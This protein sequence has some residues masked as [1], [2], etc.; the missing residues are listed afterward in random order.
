MHGLIQ[1]KF[2]NKIRFSMVIYQIS[3]CIT[4]EEFNYTTCENL[5]KGFSVQINAKWFKNDIY[6]RG[7]IAH[8]ENFGGIILGHDA[9]YASTEEERKNNIA[10]FISFLEKNKD[11]FK[12]HGATDFDLD[13]N[14]YLASAEHF[15]LLKCH[16]M[17]ELLR[18][19][20]SVTRLNIF[21]MNIREYNKLIK[22]MKKEA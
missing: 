8:K 10:E 20:I 1:V 19:G 11:I 18:C 9:L 17:K 7:E 5:L 12:S 4:G 6:Y 16:E 14:V 3:L 2:F 22:Q 13:V 21:P 15:M